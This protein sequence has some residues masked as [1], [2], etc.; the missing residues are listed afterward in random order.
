MILINKQKNL[1]AEFGMLRYKFELEVYFAFGLAN[2]LPNC[3]Q[4]IV[5]VKQDT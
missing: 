3:L 1:R 4:L 5:L 2:K